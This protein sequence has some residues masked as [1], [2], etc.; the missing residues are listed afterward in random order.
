MGGVS[1]N[2][3]TDIP[4]LTGQVIIVTGGNVGLGYETIRQLIK[5]KPSRVYLA[6]RS[7]DKAQAAIAELQKSNPNAAISFLKF[8]LAS[9]ASIKAAATIFTNTESRLDILMNNAGIMMTPPG[10]T[11]EGYEIQFGT[12][13]MGAALFTQLL[14][15]TLQ[16]TAL[17]DP[18]TRVVNLASASEKMAPTND[19]YPFS[20]LKT[21]MSGRPT[22]QRYTI[23]K[24]ADIHYTSALARREK[25]VKCISVHP[26]MV[27]TN[28]HHASTGMFLKPFLNVAVKLF[29]TPL[30]K[31]AH[32]QIWAAVSPEAKSGEYYGPVG[33]A[34]DGSKASQDEKLSEE[35][36]EWVQKELEGHL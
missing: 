34:G 7:E 22:T 27:A 11:A 16:R 36:W 29:A 32:S 18:Q 12:N 23:S 3:D 2:P 26:G 14:L 31:G 6:A 5:H 33:K 4:D 17:S 20:E 15:P 19:L 28:L 13:V 10:L 35:L 21:N 30:E 9:F 25:Q 8:D 1:F 24:I